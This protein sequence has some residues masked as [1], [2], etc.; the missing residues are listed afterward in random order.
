[1]KF[2]AP[3]SLLIAAL[4]ASTF[5]PLALRA[6]DTPLAKSMEAIN[7]SYKELRKA[8]RTPDAGQ[9]AQYLKLVAAIRVEA[10]KGKDLVPAKIEELSGAEKTTELAAYKK[11]MDDFIASLDELTK[12]INDEKWDEVNASVR[13]LNS[14]KSDGHDRFKKQE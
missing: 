3:R 13:N 11:S 10:V 14:Q 6:D 8:L 12:L 7:D 9:K 2:P 4:L 5:A 1:M